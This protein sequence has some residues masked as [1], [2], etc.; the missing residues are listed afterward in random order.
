MKED[1]EFELE[2]LNNLVFEKESR[3]NNKKR[4]LLANISFF[5]ALIATCLCYFLFR[6]AVISAPLGALL[7][8]GFAFFC[9][10][11]IYYLTFLKKIKYITSHLDLESLKN[12]IN[13]IKT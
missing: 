1:L 6:F 3:P 8:S 10:L 7:M 11:S 13:E 5:S 4:F 9:G 12:R 2:I